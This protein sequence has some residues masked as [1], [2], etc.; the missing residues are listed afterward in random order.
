MSLV[1]G[2]DLTGSTEGARIT[3]TGDPWLPSGQR[4]YF[5]NF[6]TSAFQRTAPRDFGNAGVGILRNPGTDNWDITVSKRVL[7]GSEARFIQFRTELFNAWNHTQFFRVLLDR[8]FGPDGQSV[9]PE[10]RRV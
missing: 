2:A 4:N 1:D 7:P 6:K 3:V 9:R 8:A 10:L 5:Q